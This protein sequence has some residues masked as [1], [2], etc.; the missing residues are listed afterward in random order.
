MMIEYLE[1]LIARE[2]AR[3]FLPNRVEGQTGVGRFNNHI[4]LIGFVCSKCMQQGSSLNSK[5]A[6]RRERLQFIELMECFNRLFPLLNGFTWRTSKFIKL[7]DFKIPLN[8][9]IIRWKLICLEQQILSPLAQLKFLNP[10][11]LCRREVNEKEKKTFH[12][13]PKS[14]QIIIIYAAVQRINASTAH[15][16][17]FKY[18][19]KT[20]THTKVNMK[21]NNATDEVKQKRIEQFVRLWGEFVDDVV[22]SD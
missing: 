15:K 20:E 8:L 6:E 10:H 22:S 21:F 16:N 3:E 14:F 4:V 2:N 7:F 11:T 17:I 19:Q 5:Q 12:K 18:K 13:F 9:I 1:F